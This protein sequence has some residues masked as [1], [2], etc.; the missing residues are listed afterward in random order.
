MNTSRMPALFVG[1]GS[2]MNVLEDNQ[3][4]QGWLRLGQVLQTPKAI[5]VISAHWY[6]KGTAVT[7]MLHPKTIH[8]FY[9]FP[10]ELYQITYPAPGAPELAEEIQYLLQPFKVVADNEQW[11]LDHGSWGIL[12]KMY[13]DANIPVIQLSIN[14]TESAE[15]HYQLGQKL[16]ALREKGVLLLGSGNVVHNLRAARW[17]GDTE[18]YPWALSFDQFVKDN[19]TY[20]GE[21]HPLVGYMQRPDAREAC[22]TPEHY[23]PLLYI[24]GSWDQKEPVSVPIE[25]IEMGSLSMLSV[26]I[27]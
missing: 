5:V 20:R 21:H 13:P 19:L 22:P 15:Y 23:L 24:L 14:G 12:A 18:P 11:G 25:G 2:P 7:S 1:H 8:D 27:G 26:Q 4:T 16:S 17:Q 3:Y 9:G 10:E 6:T